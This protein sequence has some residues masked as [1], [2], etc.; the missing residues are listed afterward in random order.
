MHNENKQEPD[1]Y[2][3]ISQEYQNVLLNEKIQILNH[4]LPAIR[5]K[6]QIARELG[7]LSENAEYQSELSNKTRFEQR[8]S[9]IK[10]ILNKA[11]VFNIEHT[12][13]K[14]QIYIGSN[15]IILNVTTKQI[16]KFQI[17]ST[18]EVDPSKHRISHK[19]EIARLLIGKK[20]NDVIVFRDKTYKIT[21]IKY[22]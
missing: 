12:K 1:G 8:L 3:L 20:Y 5:K 15:I 16:M 18:F 6:V 21:S 19:S 4:I 13:N 2:E 10:S 7:D 14:E 9:T 17:V 22:E 11:I